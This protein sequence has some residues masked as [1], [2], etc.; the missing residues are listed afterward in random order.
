M[1]DKLLEEIRG[2]KL[3]EQK[4]TVSD[5]KG[6]C[7]LVSR[8][9]Y[10]REKEAKN[11]SL[12]STTGNF[13]GWWDAKTDRWYLFSASTL[14]SLMDGGGYG[15]RPVL[16][17]SL[18]KFFNGGRLSKEGHNWVEKGNAVLGAIKGEDDLWMIPC[19]GVAPVEN[20]LKQPISFSFKEP[21]EGKAFDLLGAL[22]L[23]GEIVGVLGQEGSLVGVAKGSDKEE[24]LKQ[25]KLG[26]LE[27]DK[28]FDLKRLEDYYF[29]AW[30]EVLADTR[31]F[32]LKQGLKKILRNSQKE[33]ISSKS[34]TWIKGSP[35]SEKEIS[36]I[37]WTPENGLFFKN[38]D[39]SKIYS[40][41]DPAADIWSN[42]VLPAY[43]FQK[44]SVALEGGSRGYKRVGDVKLASFPG[45]S[46]PIDN[47]K[48]KTSRSKAKVGDKVLCLIGGRGIVEE[49]DFAGFSY[50]ALISDKD[51][52]QLGWERCFSTQE[53]LPGG[54]LFQ[55]HEREFVC[56]KLI[57]Q[58]LV[59]G[60][61]GLLADAI[62]L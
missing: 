49:S 10:M 47:K 38:N 9:V 24:L 57:L 59:S 28:N 13:Y 53:A 35:I 51:G 30:R 19:D 27:I 41:Q 21:V 16:I 54:V 22:Y 34:P 40:P 23:D 52:N 56:D 15:E 37:F 20:L 33:I 26:T 39:K 46:F 62:A 43:S 3:I 6:M 48:W 11:I 18:P 5:K 44:G 7:D 14:D 8:K 1:D 58:R 32:W 2:W 50:L 4:I 25:N 31:Y 36:F 55:E 61:R 12:L 42:L 45:I 29:Y 60:I 17:Y